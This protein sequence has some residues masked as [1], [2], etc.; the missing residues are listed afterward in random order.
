M[1][2]NSSAVW[3]TLSEKILASMV[4]TPLVRMYLSSQRAGSPSYNL[5]VSL[6][7]TA[8]LVGEPLAKRKTFSL[9]QSLSYKE[10]WHCK[11]MPE[12]LHKRI[13]YP[14]CPAVTDLSF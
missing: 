8:P 2:P 4:C 6:R 11:A 13:T 1:Q 9:R 10:R 7:S 14:L 5:S 12:R 3:I